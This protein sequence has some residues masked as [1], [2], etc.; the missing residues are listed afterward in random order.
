MKKN[1]VFGHYA[2]NVWRKTFKVMKLT[3][4]LVLLG[5]FSVSAEGFAQGGNISLKMEHVSLEDILQELKA[6][7]EYTFVYSDHQIENVKV[8]LFE[9]KD[10]N[11]EVVM[12]ECLQ[13]TDL[14]F[15]VENDVVVI[16]KKTPVVIEEVKQ[17]KK[18]IKG[19]VTD[20]DGN[21][22]PGVSVVI[23]GTTNGAATDINGKYTISFDGDNVVL[24]YSFVGMIT[25]E[26][27]YSGQQLIDVKLQAD[28]EG[29]DEIV[30]VGY[31][32]M[33]R[34]DLTGAVSRLD[35]KVIEQSTQ[36]SIGS[37]IQGQLAG[38][39]VLTGSSEPG[40][41]VRIRIRG[42][43]TI[44]N[45]AD[46]LIVV[47]G[48]PMPSGYNINDINPN[49]VESL[50][51]L[52][53]AS[54]SAIYGSRASAGVLEI[55]TKR[56][57]E[58]TKPEIS[59]SYTYSIKTLCDDISALNASQ[60]NELFDE[61]LTN[62]VAGR[63]NI[64][65][66]KEAVKNYIRPSNGRN[67][68]EFYKPYGTAGTSDTDWVDLMIKPAYSQEH[69]VS[70]RG[71]DQKIQYSFSYGLNREEGMLIGSDYSRH[72][73]NFTYDQQ[74]SKNVKVGFNLLG[75]V[76]DKNGTATIKDA[77]T[78]RPDVP[79][80]NEDGSYHLHTFEYYGSVNQV[81]NP[82]I[83]ANDVTN[84]T[85]GKSISVS[86]YAEIKFLKDFKLTSRYSLYFD[87]RHKEQYY[88]ST[89]RVG[90]NYSDATGRLNDTQRENSNMTFTNYLTYM[91]E[92]KEHDLT[93]LIG[94]DLNQ[95]EYKYITER[96]LNFAD[97]KI[98]NAPWQAADNL[99]ADGDVTQTSSIGYYSRLQYKFKDRY[100]L[101]GTMRID[102]SSRFSPEN[103]NGFFPSIAA[104]YII[105]EE[106]F[107]SGIKNSINL[108]KLRV[109]AG[110]TGNDNV[111][112][113]S[114]MAQYQ[115]GIDYMG[116]P[117][118]RPTS[119]GNDALKWESTTEYNIGLDFGFLKNSRIRGSIDIYKK[120]VEDMLFAMPMAPSTGV[121]SVTQNFA[122]LT[123]KGIELNL[124][125]VII[126]N[127]GFTWEV[128]FNISKNENVLTK[129]GLPRASSTQGGTWLSYY[130]IE[131]G[132]PL[133]LIYGYKT[134]GLFKSYDEVDAY[135]AL[136]PDKKYQ[137]SYQH[138]MPG[139][140]KFVDVSGDGYIGAGTG[141]D[142]DEHEDR[143]VIGK[144]QADFWGGCFT[145]LEYKG[146]RLDIRATF[147]K[148]G[149]KYWKY[150]ESQ[151][152]LSNIN[153]G[154]VNTLALER[155]TPEN[156]DAKY[157]IFR[158]SYYTNKVNDFWL[159]DASYFKIQEINLSYYVPKK[160]L[161]KT[162]FIKRLNVYASVNNVALF[163]KYPGYNVESFSPSNPLQGTMMDYSAY[164]NERT[165]KF[166]A[167]IVF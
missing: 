24:I 116:K 164:P 35:S 153:P 61:G 117:G 57:S 60:F 106:P 112:A 109:S 158:N 22:L 36:V 13:G 105:S 54:A 101:T 88:P 107:F 124:S 80:Y 46:P 138:S 17:E 68:Y 115:S 42:D 134:D 86:P 45:G 129:L 19:T 26:L 146:L 147:Q 16:R 128:G 64:R 151:F 43:A 119:L 40:S 53:G 72:T 5:I 145:S 97:D 71:G 39:E 20:I 7:S 140:I 127:K 85:K 11:L 89:T 47:N 31:G 3:V 63:F 14:E 102:R 33:K 121:G 98:M 95:K 108:L 92:Y 32:T 70:L 144:T 161:E 58:Y 135:E 96:Y 122:S 59:Y 87:M 23:K 69:Y 38:V 131:E 37:M 126:E 18:T 52:K 78:M 34:K 141:K 136:N 77:T 84:N 12:N 30:V 25:Q 154:N 110:K 21:T 103:R 49:D 148:G 79:A 142:D 4:L 114:W 150:G 149:S 137:E 111:G 90:K 155:W 15:Y 51:V 27:I 118:V 65:D 167:R 41:P 55:T 66:G 132:Q 125:G 94:V 143:R 6:H 163:T 165:F 67:Y 120:D 74:F 29:L 160:Y 123:N 1:H 83:L 56:G 99:W 81:D 44:N 157:P 104:G 162:G 9:V 139:D 75:N 73:A 82:L 76:S 159:Y 130:V 100:L 113:Y 93:A 2:S 91:K 10:A 48:V 28:S 133:G 8:D 166:G 50:D 152:Q 62:Y 156:P